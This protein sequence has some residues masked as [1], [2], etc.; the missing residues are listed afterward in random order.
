AAK[1]AARTI[2]IVFNMA[3]DPVRIGLVA[4]LARPGG[5]MTGINFFNS[6]VAAKRLELLHELVPAPARIA[7]L[8]H[9]SAA[10]STHAV[11]RDA[12]LAAPALGLQIRS[13]EVETSQDINAAFATFARERPDALFTGGGAFFSARRVQ[14]AQ[15][16]ARHGLPASASDRQFAEVGG[17]MSYGS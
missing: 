15:L 14:L 9:P 8:S 16:A 4:S 3:D 10:P 17:L 2:P 13:I 1:A 12:Q 11:L 5:N 7:M 6:E